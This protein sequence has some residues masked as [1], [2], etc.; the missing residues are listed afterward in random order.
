MGNQYYYYFELPKIRVDR[1]RA[2]K[3]S[4][5]FTLTS[6]SLEIIKKTVGFLM[7]QGE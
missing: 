5:N 3:N 1:A 2:T 6:I 4:V 7:I